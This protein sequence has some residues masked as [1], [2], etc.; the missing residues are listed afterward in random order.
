MQRHHLQPLKRRAHPP[1][2]PIPTLLQLHHQLALAP[3]PPHSARSRAR[4]QCLRVAVAL[5]DGGDDDARGEPRDFGVR[6][7]AGGG[8]GV[9]LGFRGGEAEEGVDD[10]AVGGE[11]N[12]AGGGG[13]EAAHGE[14]AVGGVGERAEGGEDVLGL[15]EVGGTDDTL[16]FPVLDVD[17]GRVVGGFLAR[18]S[19][20]FGRRLGRSG[21]GGVEALP[22]DDA[23]VEADLIAG[24]NA[25][26]VVRDA[27]VDGDEATGNEVVCLAAAVGGA[28]RF[29]DA[30]AFCGRGG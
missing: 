4:R 18:R 17:E 12:E 29:V 7:T 27:A 14:D 22:V 23:A 15:A 5:R 20:G 9:G 24:E 2:L 26:A 3:P 11:E 19:G 28:Q 16:G 30:D 10:G 25:H 13:V 21:G 6:C 8:D 1:N